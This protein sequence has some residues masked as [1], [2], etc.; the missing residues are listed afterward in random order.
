MADTVGNLL[1]PR[2][3]F[4]YETDSGDTVNFQQDRSVGL[5]AGNALATTSERPVSVSNRYLRG[6]YLLVQAQNDASVRKRIVVG[7]ADSALFAADASSNI[8]I[9]TRVFV[10]T[11]RVG[12]AV[13]YLRLTP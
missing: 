2:A 7:D 6:R 12:E 13:S 8:T 1:G 4:V 11:G 5:A 3:T 9:N 10:I